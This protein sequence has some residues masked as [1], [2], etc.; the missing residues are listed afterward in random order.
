VTTTLVKSSCVSVEV[1]AES[2]LFASGS[3]I[4]CMLN[5]IFPN[6]CPNTLS[7]IAVQQRWV[8]EPGIGIQDWVCELKSN[9]IHILKIHEKWFVNS[10]YT[11]S[12]LKYS[13]V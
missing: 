4:M 1:S 9:S 11:P 6:Q 7:H 13:F 5:N 8:A 12:V 3:W 10:T 2:Q